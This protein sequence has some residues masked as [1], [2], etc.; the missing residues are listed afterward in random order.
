MSDHTPFMIDRTERFEHL[1]RAPIVEAVIQLR[2]RAESMPAAD[3]LEA[4]LKN[5]LPQYPQAKAI[6]SVSVAARVMAGSPARS[7]VASEAE[8]TWLGLRVQTS[9]GLNVG[10]FT[11]D[12]FSYSRL[13]PY[14]NWEKFIGEAL[15]LWQVHQELCGPSEIARLGVRFINRFEVPVAGLDPSDYLKGVPSP[16]GAF[17]RS[18]FLYRDELAAGD[19]PY[20]ATV[21]RTIQPGPEASSGRAGLLL[22]VDVFTL[23][24]FPSEQSMIERRLADLHW[25]KNRVFFDNVTERALKSCR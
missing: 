18:G 12:F 10:M 2:A 13:K 8:H 5:A 17:L 21:M 9:D 16:P 15:R 25:L 11:R 22:D 19:L 14:E 24:P 4:Y 3:R 1:P 7:S 6:G 23:E 20:G